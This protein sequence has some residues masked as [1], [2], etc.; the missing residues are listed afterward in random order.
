MRREE[1]TENYQDQLMLKDWTGVSII[2][3]EVGY[4]LSSRTNANY[5][6]KKYPS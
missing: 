5:K 6:D 1:K 2:W 3:N 4:H